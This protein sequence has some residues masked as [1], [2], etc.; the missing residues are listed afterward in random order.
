M[1]K[2]PTKKPLIACIDDEAMNLELLKF[3]I[4]QIDCDVLAIQHSTKAL[5]LLQQDIPDVIL[6]DVRMPDMDGFEL[7]SVI[8]TKKKLKDIP[9]IFITGMGKTENK[10]KG[11]ELGGVD[12]V[13]KPFNKHELLARIKTHLSL[14]EAKKKVLK[15]AADLKKEN[16]L[17]DRLFSIIGHDLR[18]PL[19]AIK[20]QLDFIL[21]GIIDPR[22]ANFIP[23]TVHSLNATTDEAFNLLDNLLGWAKSESGSLS[24]IKEKVNLLNLVEQCARLQKLALETKNIALRITIAQDAEVYADMNMIK[25]VLRNLL[26]NAIKFTP[27]DGTISIAAQLENEFWNISVTDSGVGIS[28][29]DLPKVLNTKQ[30]F[31]KEGTEQE[32][33]TGL[34]L[35]LCQDFIVKNGGTLWVESSLG[36]GSSFT[37]SVPVAEN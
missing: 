26:S 31:S 22:D 21:R 4:K 6:L 13:T 34:G 25:T 15:Q 24:I 8:K 35:I 36:K 14:S 10:V 33:G 3:T 19:S 5:A 2:V 7:C 17:K 27:V 28:K 37:F 32:A 1:N 12:Y 29:E 9:I 11:F 16:V 20:M 30:H 18:S 23:K